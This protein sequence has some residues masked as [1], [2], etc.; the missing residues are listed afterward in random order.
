MVRIT[1]RDFLKYCSITA[2]ALG[3]SASTL[4]KLENAAA[5]EAS[6]GGLPVVWVAGAACTGC[7]M[8]L[9]NSAYYRTLEQLT[10][11]DIDLGYLDTLMGTAGAYINGAIYSGANA[12]QEARDIYAAGGY[13]LVVE[14]AIPMGTPLGSGSLATPGGY[15]EIGDLVG[16]GNPTFANVVKAFS[17]K[18]AA[19]IAVGTCSSWGGIPGARGTMTDARGLIA[20][21]NYN[22]S[23]V[24]VPTSS[25]D[26]NAGL[27]TGTGLEGKVI[28]IPGCPPHPDWIVGTIA[29]VV[30][31]MTNGAV[32][33]PSLDVLHR[34]IDNGF[35]EYQC[36]A[37][38]CPW[39][40][41]NTDS[42][43]RA[44][45]CDSN[46]DYFNCS[47]GTLFA[48][49]DHNYRYPEGNSRAIGKFKW[50]GTDLGCLGIIGCKGRKTVADCSKRRWN[51]TSNT[52]YGVN[53]CVGT[54]GSCHGCTM[55][56]FPDKVGKLFT[57]L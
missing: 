36:N 2:G 51:S 37:G 10:M 45:T 27:L 20:R 24:R 30:D 52:Q 9:A 34:P 29:E 22:S 23:N 49:P 42:G 48:D 14:G 25:L 35:K 33:L 1:R 55:P 56:G 57:I 17:Y 15:C 18:A 50:S 6:L 38:P 46:G 26:R 47:P 43:R 44:S 40:F 54:R 16:D 5:K 39:R 41:N 21:F 12:V 31:T 4:L 28:N 19:I 7:T 13:V 8:S 3:L 53:L 11:D 32:V